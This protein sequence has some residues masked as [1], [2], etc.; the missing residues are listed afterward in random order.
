MRYFSTNRQ[1]EIVDF[2]TATIQ[3]QAPDKGLYFPEVIP[4]LKKEFLQ[5]LE[6]YSNEEIAFDV[7]KPYTGTTIPDDRLF[8]IV[9]AVLVIIISRAST[10]CTV[11]P[12]A[13]HLAATIC[14]EIHSP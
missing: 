3:G 14:D 5:K 1:A 7:I 8:D 12:S 6:T 2:K 13:L 9:K 11:K 10:H 4:I